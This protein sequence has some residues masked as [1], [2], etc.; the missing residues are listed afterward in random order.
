M[1]PTRFSSLSQL[2]LVLSGFAAAVL[3]LESQGLAIWAERLEVG[4]GRAAAVWTTSVMERTLAPL[5]IDEFRGEL[6]ADLYRLGWTDDPA[7]LNGGMRDESRPNTSTV[8]LRPSGPGAS[9]RRQAG[10]RSQALSHGSVDRLAASVPT[11]T[12]LQP[13]PAAADGHARVVALVG[14]SMMAVGLSDG[15][16][17][18][19]ASN[20]NVRVLKAFRSGT[21]LARPDVFDW[22]QEYPAMIGNAHPD[23]VIVAMGANDAQG[24]VEDGKVLPYGSPEWIGAYWQR[25][26]AFLG[27]L[28]DNGAR[29]VWVGLP[30][31]RSGKFNEKIAEINRIA[32]DVVSR[33]PQATWWNPQSL[34]GDQSG[35]YRE[36]GIM[37][38]GQ[39]ARLRAADGI[40]LSDPGAML[41][42]P[43]L[44][45][46]L[47]AP[48]QV[49][50][51]QLSR[52]H[53]NTIKQ[54]NAAS[55]R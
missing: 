28:T 29:V 26:A 32:Y 35:Q 8:V 22:M 10:S 30:P 25:T 14:D 55:R 19:T 2:T 52:A 1:K 44:L 21:G 47:N 31:M 13:L 23:A 36:F 15:L 49:V 16:I 37:P 38:D 43:S 12:P 3:L 53:T 6:L 40:H 42:V 54:P 39:A 45:Q 50:T 5:G 46:W 20:P 33:N 11:L 41:L 4:H 48:S 24:F 9:V 18:Q 27:L 34:I 7:L 17:Q 51:A